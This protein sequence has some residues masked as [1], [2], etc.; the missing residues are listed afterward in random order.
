MN[1]INSTLPIQI[2]VLS[3]SGFNNYTLMLN[4]KK[5]QTKSMI[6]LEINGEYLAELY[7]QD[8]IMQFKNLT[9]KPK[10]TRFDDGLALLVEL[11][12][13]NLSFKDYVVNSLINS[14]NTQEYEIF[15]E[16]FFAIN[17]NV[18]HIPFVFE[19]KNCLFQMKK[20]VKKLEIYLYFSVFGA[21]KIILLDN[22]ISIY[23]PFLKVCNF[24]SENLKV[25]VF[26]E[27]NISP[28]FIFKKLA[29][30]KYE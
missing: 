29:K 26:H 23:S 27:K 19:D 20:G 18:Y 1:L 8:G 2:K 16:M 9:K 15:K 6:E 17:E 10:I 3:K 24:L 7:M 11:L 25:D 4:T 28:F 5:I 21:I 14:K 30:A 12:E 13:N 22:D